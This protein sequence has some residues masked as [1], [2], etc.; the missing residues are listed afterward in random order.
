MGDP[1]IE[2]LFVLVADTGLQQVPTIIAPTDLRTHPDA[3]LP[4]EPAWVTE[5]YAELRTA[6]ARF[7]R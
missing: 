3:A 2:E 4:S 7:R 6:L 5:L 1:A